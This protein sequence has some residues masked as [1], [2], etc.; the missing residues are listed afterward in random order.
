MGQTDP[1][2]RISKRAFLVGAAAGG[3]AGVAAGR[4]GV[5][6]RPPEP[7]PEPAHQ[8]SYAQCGEDLIAWYMFREFN[9]PQ[10]TYLDIGANHPTELSNTYLFYTLGCRGLLVEPNVDLVPLLREVR[11]EDTT[12]NIGIGPVTTEA[13]Y[14]RVTTPSWNTFDKATAEH[15]DRVTKGQVK[16]VGVVKVPLVNVNE[17]LARHH[18]GRTPDFVSLD[19]EGL[20]LDILRSLD[21]EKHRPKVVCVET[22]VAGTRRQK[23]EAANFLTEKGY[24]ARGST[25]VNTLFLDGRLIT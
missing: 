17:V 16:V 18:G 13:D 10:P 5:P 24:V 4:W 25:F 6:Y 20:E 23:L 9:I 8:K 14:Y 22:L 11:P 15:Y 19:V 12:L 21:W 2:P 3:G 1:A 7:P